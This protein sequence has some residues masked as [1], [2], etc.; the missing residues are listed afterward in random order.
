MKVVILG[1]G[2]AGLGAATVFQRAGAEWTLLE[3]NLW[4]GGLSASFASEGF[5]WDIGGHVLFSHYDDFNRVLDEVMPGDQWFCHQRR[6]FIRTREAWVPYPFQYNI[7]HLSECDQRRCVEGVREAAAQTSVNPPR[8]F[9][10]WIYRS[11]GR[12]L[13]D[14]F[15]IP[16]NRKVWAG[17]P[18]EMAVQWMGDR[19]AIP[20]VERMERHLSSQSDDAVWGPN[21]EFRFP[22]HGGTGS[23]WQALAGSLPASRLQFGTPAVSVDPGK[24]RVI[25]HDGQVFPYDV[26]LSTLPVDQLTSMAGLKRY[27]EACQGLVRTR[28]WVGGFGLPGVAPEAAHNKSWMYFP[29]PE[30]PFYRVTVFSHYSRNNAP[31]GCNSLMVEIAFRPGDPVPSNECLLSQSAEGLKRCGLIDRHVE[32]MHTWSFLADYGYP[33]PA[34]ARDGIL[35]QVLPGLKSMGIYSRGRFGAWKYEVGNMDHSFMQGVE[36][37]GNILS[38][39]PEITLSQPDQVNAP[40]A[41]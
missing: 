5:T 12:G 9:E 8:T 21:N 1:A 14:L 29:E 7:R 17:P 27:S 32:P 35:D 19:V 11:M 18:A 20:D 6:A 34:L 22:K 2:P 28:T 41:R 15:M 40:R 10:D 4:P 31:P 16:Y 23:I 3:K 24:R 37:A 13:A 33:V 30:Y 36:A 38:G 25:T 39:L 26:L